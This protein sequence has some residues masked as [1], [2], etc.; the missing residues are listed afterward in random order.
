MKLNLYCNGVFISVNKVNGFDKDN[1][2]LTTNY[3][4]LESNDDVGKIKCTD[5]VFDLIKN[6]KKYTELVLTGFFDTWSKEFVVCGYKVKE[7][8]A[9]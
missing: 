4:C 8:K 7:S 2:P 3:I 1:R 6:E 9:E 5:A